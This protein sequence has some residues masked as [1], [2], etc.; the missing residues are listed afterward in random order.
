MC[1]LHYDDP[2]RAIYRNAL[3]HQLA[4]TRRILRKKAA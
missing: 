4:L 2:V 1:T 3:S